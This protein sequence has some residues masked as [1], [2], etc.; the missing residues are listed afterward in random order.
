M[1][2]NNNVCGKRNGTVEDVNAGVAI[3]PET[4]TVKT[5]NDTDAT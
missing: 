3:T 4:P 5:S 1:N 2:K